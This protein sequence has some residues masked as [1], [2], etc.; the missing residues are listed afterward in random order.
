MQALGP[1]EDCGERLDGGADDVV[2]GL[3]GRQ[4][5]ARG[6][7]VESELSAPLVAC[8]EAVAHDLCP[9]PPRRPVLGYLL[10]QVVVGIEEEREPGRELVH[11]QPGIEGG[12][13][14][15]YGVGEGESEFLDGGGS[16]LSYVVA[17]DRDRVPSG[18]L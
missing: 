12:F 16:S 15:G 18:Q 7:G 9:H 6:L 14:V 11:I 13:D 5:G 10:E 4:R 2:L 17:A 3:L 1:A 8:A